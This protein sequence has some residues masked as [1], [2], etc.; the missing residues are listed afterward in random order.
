MFACKLPAKHSRCLTS[1]RAPLSPG[2]G[3]GTVSLGE[4]GK[5]RQAGSLAIGA[6]GPAC[7]WGFYF[8]KVLSTCHPCWAFGGGVTD[9]TARSVF[10]AGAD[11]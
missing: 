9:H 1:P 7:L 11:F 10:G 8:C 3:R 4:V 2:S 5:L 6:G